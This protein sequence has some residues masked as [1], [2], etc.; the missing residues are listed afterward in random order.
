MQT[1]QEGTPA[2]LKKVMTGHKKETL[3]QDKFSMLRVLTFLPEKECA[4][5]G[6]Q[7]GSLFRPNREKGMGCPASS[8]NE[9]KATNIL[10]IIFD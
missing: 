3:A 8:R 2:G 9:H 5:H 6:Y 4:K 10:P 1:D 7:M